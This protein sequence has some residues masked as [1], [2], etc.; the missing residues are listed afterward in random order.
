VLPLQ[1][2][3]QAGDVTHDDGRVQVFGYSTRTQEL[4]GLQIFDLEADAHLAVAI[5]FIGFADLDDC[6]VADPSVQR[7][8]MRE[9]A[10]NELK[11]AEP[12]HR[13]MTA[14][15]SLSAPARAFAASLFPYDNSIAVSITRKIC[16]T[17]GRIGIVKLK[18]V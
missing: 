3:L 11:Y 4:S 18:S 6:A 1:A 8:M 17:R 13:D 12:D 5:E 16:C 9:R 2:H 10:G 7:V 15:I 14:R